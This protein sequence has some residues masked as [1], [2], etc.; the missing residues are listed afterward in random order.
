MHLATTKRPKKSEDVLKVKSVVNSLTESDSNHSLTSELK[1]ID[2]PKMK[3]WC[4]SSY[5]K[6]IQDAADFVSSVEH[7]HK[8]F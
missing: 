8:D 4:L 5:P 3:M 2:H 7:K 6:G 1:G